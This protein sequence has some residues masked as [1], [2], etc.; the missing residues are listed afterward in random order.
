MRVCIEVALR[1]GAWIETSL[2]RARGCFGSVAPSRRGVD[3]NN[4]A[5]IPT[6]KAYKSPPAQGRGSKHQ[7]SVLDRLGAVSPLA[8]GVDRNKVVLPRFQ[9]LQVAPVAWIETCS[10][11]SSTD[12]TRV[13][14][15]GGAWI[16]TRTSASGLTGLRQL[17]HLTNPSAAVPPRTTA[18]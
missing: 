1:A 18:G 5:D 4:Q 15:R 8:Q 2:S 3:R 14:P 9:S 6:I 12:S 17:R 7:A 11:P 16:E 13:A 10:S